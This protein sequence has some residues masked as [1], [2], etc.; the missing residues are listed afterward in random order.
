M[1][2]HP[3]PDLDPRR[4]PD[5]ATLQAENDRMRAKNLSRINWHVP[6]KVSPNRK[7]SS[8]LSN[9]ILEALGVLNKML[10]SAYP[11]VIVADVS[12]AGPDHNFR[13]R[14]RF[15]ESY[16][17]SPGEFAKHIAEAVR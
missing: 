1:L 15:T 5:V 8:S 6:S 2:A 9:D 3:P 13:I 7:Y 14:S 12:E 11:E 10:N 4:V 16:T 17:P